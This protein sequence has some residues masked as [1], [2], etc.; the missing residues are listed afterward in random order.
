MNGL[1]F[2]LEYMREL[3]HK[4]L[5]QNGNDPDMY[6]IDGGLELELEMIWNTGSNF[7]VNDSTRVIWIKPSWG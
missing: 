4:W 1:E 7:I 5:N 2:D 3:Y 6:E